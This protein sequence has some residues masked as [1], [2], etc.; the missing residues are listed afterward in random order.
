MKY[1]LF[2]LAAS[3]TAFS[4]G[5]SKQ[6]APKNIDLLADNLSGK[7]EQVTEIPYKTDSTGKTGEQDSCCVLT[8][9]YNEKGYAS[10]YTS[11]NKA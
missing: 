2:L 3:V 7:V 9:N 5:E 10:A 4:C 8:T 6:E 11:K 1:L